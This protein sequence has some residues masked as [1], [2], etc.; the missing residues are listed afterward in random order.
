MATRNNWT[1][2]E[3]TL[4][5]YYYCQIP[6]GKIHQSNPE[7]KRIGDLIGRSYAAV[8]RKM[9]NLAHYDPSQRERNIVGLSHASKLDRIIVE[10]Y[11]NDWDSLAFEAKS[12]EA[13]YLGK[14][15]EEIVEINDE[16]PE[17]QDVL[18]IVATRLNQDFFREAVLSS[19]RYACCITGMT[20]PDLLIAS[21]IK[22]W[23]DSDWKKERTNPRNGLCLN[24]L[25]DKAFDRGL[26][27]V[28][29]DFTI[30]VSSK[31]SGTDEGTAWIKQCNKQTIILPDKFL[32][33]KE[34]L[35][36]HNDVVFQP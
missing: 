21:H 10:K 3:T 4:A 6:F 25:H 15:I 13:T 17:G 34:Y 36:Y 7:I 18:Q 27:T 29:P 11:I 32:P 20:G 31:L 23:K 16:F 19:Y 14:S 5:F 26:L 28:L 12:I 30:R 33:S 2:A 22:P 24:A 1:E 35:E 8:V 9:G